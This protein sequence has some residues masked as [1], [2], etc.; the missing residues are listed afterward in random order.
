M[1]DTCRLCQQERELVQ[2]HIIPNFVIKWLK[3]SGATPFLR[4]QGSPDT[5]IQDKKEYLLCSECEQK[6]SAWEGKFADYIFYPVIRQ[7]KE[8]FEYDEWLLKFI[9]SISWRLL[10]TSFTDTNVEDN[11]SLE[12]A[13]RDWRRILLGKDSLSTTTRDH[14]LILLGETES[15]PSDFPEGWEFYAS[16]GIDGTT[17]HVDDG[18][19]VYAKF[20]QM[21]FISCINPESIDGVDTARVGQSGI[22]ETPQMIHSPWS[23]IPVRAAEDIS[24]EK[25]SS[26]EQEKILTHIQE[27][28]EQLADSK[29]IETIRR[30]LKRQGDFNHDPVSYLSED[31]CPVCS[32]NHRIIESIPN[33]RLSREDVSEIAASEQFNFVRGVF[34]NLEDSEPESVDLTGTIVLSTATG[35]RVV[36]LLDPG[37]VIDREIKH[38]DTAD[39]VAMGETLYQLVSDEY[40][41]WM[42]TH[43]PNQEFTID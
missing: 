10:V 42:R 19:H 16:R 43:A 12:R 33:R 31:K 23:E 7:Q 38:V 36:S 32:T 39:D 4:E 24:G 6:F 22:I 17:V 40:G 21:Y 3:K 27:H 13:E 20:P 14:H 41:E 34:I 15:A 30:K 1:I 29:T 35:T 18:V 26:H 25:S 8:T 9:I 28:P 2:S 5:R 37:W 11:E